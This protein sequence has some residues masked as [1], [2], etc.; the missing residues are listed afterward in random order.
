[1]FFTS[2]EI[3]K[4]S[5]EKYMNNKT[6]V[7]TVK[8]D[9]Y[10]QNTDLLT[11]INKPDMYENDEPI[12]K[13]DN[14]YKNFKYL[15]DSLLSQD[16][17]SITLEDNLD[18]YHISLCIFKI[19]QGLDIPFLQ[20]LF[21][22]NSTGIKFPSKQLELK[23]IQNIINDNDDNDDDELNNYFFDNIQ[24]IF[25]VTFDIDDI[26]IKNLLRGF[27]FHNN[28]FYI[29]VD[30]T[31]IYN[32]YDIFYTGD[33]KFSIID[34][35]I[36]RT[37]INDI[38]IPSEYTSLF[39]ENE[40]I[41]YLVD[42]DNNNISLPI[43][44]YSCISDNEGI[45]SNEYYSSD[46]QMSI[47]NNTI[48]HEIYGNI[49]L[50]SLDAISN[51]YEN[52]KRFALFINDVENLET[53][54]ITNT[55]KIDVSDENIEI[56]NNETKEENENLEEKKDEKTPENENSEEDDE[57][58]PESEN[59]EENDKETP[60]SENLEDNGDED[61]KETPES[62]NLEENEKEKTPESENLEE[63]EDEEEKSS[64]EGDSET[65][66]DESSS[67]GDSET[68]EDESGSEDESETEEDESGS[69]DESETEEDESE[70]EED[71]SSSEDESETEEEEV[72]HKIFKIEENG[73][74]Y[75]GTYSLD[76][77]IEI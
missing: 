31:D 45:Y 65:E 55:S 5:S 42:Y 4:H 58:T 48:D 73:K 34:E 21:S 60:E 12:I 17:N 54:T 16:F 25:K 63:N 2:P 23:V 51:N 56:Q 32:N 49:F 38:P 69:D 10:S 67:E 8:D 43:I 46:N 47:I 53:K 72:L 28:A 9:S 26:D 27:I 22:N 68:E 29:F 13:D 66:E 24:S 14:S 6:K 44:C 19:N 62:E 57:K 35:I 41:K 64:S 20:Y 71:K 3:R 61:D 18:E 15:D 75:Y 7:D 40:D 30:I 39:N 37:K 59:L 36:N 1:M 74:T 77:F 70:T 50:F 52:I 76:Y 11:P 33:F